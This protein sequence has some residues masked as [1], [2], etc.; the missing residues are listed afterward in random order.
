M[1]GDS[2]R[3]RAPRVRTTSGVR[4]AGLQGCAAKDAVPTLRWTVRRVRERA[5][6]TQDPRQPAEVIEGRVAF[7]TL[8]RAHGQ[9]GLTIGVQ[10]DHAFH[11]LSQ[12]CGRAAWLRCA[13]AHWWPRALSLVS[14]AARTPTTI[15]VKP[16][17]M[18]RAP[19]PIPAAT[20]AD[21]DAAVATL[22]KALERRAKRRSYSP[23][24]STRRRTATSRTRRP[25]LRRQPTRRDA[26]A[27]LDDRTSAARRRGS[28][29]VPRR[30]RMT[31]WARSSPPTVSK[32]RSR[33]QR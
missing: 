8:P 24:T 26:E 22:E 5:L 14:R 29:R 4:H 18:P 12:Y 31:N 15:P 6:R 13:L 16:R 32:T 28:G 27:A 11:A 3:R 30:R 9:T 23:P 7:P 25:R 33:R 17:L 20:V 21:L 2:A 19:P 1:R 10:E